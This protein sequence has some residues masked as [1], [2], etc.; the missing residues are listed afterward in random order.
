VRGSFVH[1][2]DGP[3]IVIGK[4]GTPHPRLVTGADDRQ[5]LHLIDHLSNLKRNGWIDTAN[6]SDRWTTRPGKGMRKLWA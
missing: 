1:D 3:S 4:S 5:G 2:D 6:V